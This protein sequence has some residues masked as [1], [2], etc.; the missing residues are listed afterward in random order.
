MSARLIKGTTRAI[1]QS[2]GT[3]PVMSDKFTR[4]VTVGAITEAPSFK[5][6]AEIP[7]KLV[8]FFTFESFKQLKDSKVK[9]TTGLDL[10][11]KVLG[12]WL[13]YK[14][15]ISKFFIRETKNGSWLNGFQGL[16]H[17]VREKRC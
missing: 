1:F 14:T 15:F 7:S 12:N 5:S 8:V 10:I 11:F 6:R 13:K 16:G 2:H 3:I 4:N 9:K 17:S